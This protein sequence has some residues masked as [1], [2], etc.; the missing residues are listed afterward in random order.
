MDGPAPGFQGESPPIWS[1][2]VQE[3]VRLFIPHIQVLQHVDDL[4]L[5]RGLPGRNKI[6]LHFLEERGYKVSQNAAQLCQTS[7]KYPGLVLSEGCR[8]LSTN[9]MKPPPPSHRQDTGTAQGLPGITGFCRCWIPGFGKIACPLYQLVRVSQARNAQVLAWEPEAQRAFEKL[10]RL[11]C[12]PPS[13]EPPHGKEFQPACDR[14]EGNGPGSPEALKLTLGND[15]TALSPHN[16]TGM[17]LSKGSP[18]HSNSCLL[19]CQAMLVA[20]PVI[21]IKT[22]PPSS[23]NISP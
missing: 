16:V 8:A 20:G 7:V 21:Q 23:S 2:P 12:R 9:G 4:L 3:S 13:P 17:L 5:G 11:Y 6:L 19:K 15:F 1:G 22:R 18:W 10:E 14:T